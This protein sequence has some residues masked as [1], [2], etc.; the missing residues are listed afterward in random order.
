MFWFEITRF[1]LDNYVTAKFKMIKQQINKK[2]IATYFDMNL[3]TNI[4]KAKLCPHG[5]CPTVCWTICSSA[6][7]SAKERM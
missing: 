1:K 7:D 4:S 2:I 5:N 6:Q 3:F